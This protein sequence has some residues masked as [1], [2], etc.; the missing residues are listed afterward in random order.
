VGKREE[1]GLVLIA[2]HSLLILTMMK[3]IHIVLEKET[4]MIHI[5]LETVM[6]HVVLEIEKD[7][8]VPEKEIVSVVIPHS[9][10]LPLLRLPLQKRPP[11]CSAERTGSHPTRSWALAEAEAVLLAGVVAKVWLPRPSR[12]LPWRMVPASVL[13]QPSVRTLARAEGRRRRW[14]EAGEGRRP[15]GA[16]RPARGRPSGIL[17]RRRAA[18]EGAAR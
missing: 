18:R 5:A 15:A 6:I 9:I 17:E 10:P 1:E 8:S 7:C 16:Q 3:M 2:L 12:T 11:R 13:E 14:A 4:V